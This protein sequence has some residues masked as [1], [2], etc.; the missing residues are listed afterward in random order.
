MVNR[1]SRHTRE[2]SYMAEITIIRKKL[3]PHLAA[4]NDG[5]V[6]SLVNIAAAK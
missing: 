2:F 4:L 3:C 6:S 1:A 5:E